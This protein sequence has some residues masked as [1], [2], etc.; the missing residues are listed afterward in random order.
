[1]RWLPLLLVLALLPA[2]AP[3]KAAASGFPEFNGSVYAI[4]A[5]G[6]VLYVGGSF[7]SVVAGG[8][9][10]PRERLA[11]FDAR[12]GSLLGWAPRADRTVRA[13][14]VAGTSVYAG[15]DFGRVSGLRR[16]N[17]VRLDAG[18][19]AVGRFKHTVRGAPYA[20]ATGSG[21]LYVAGSFTAV[22][23]LRRD[24]LA[25]FSLTTD[26]LDARWRPRADD[27]VHSIAAGGARVYVGGTFGAVSGVA[28]TQRVAAVSA[29]TGAVDGGFRPTA[30]GQVNGLAVDATGVYAATG[31][32]GGRAIAWTTNGG[33]RWQRLF[34]GDAV[35]VATAG[36]VTYLGGHFD[37]A[38][39]TPANGARGTCTDRSVA[40]VKMAAM[41]S[42]TGALTRWAPR[43]NGVIGVRTLEVGRSVYA[44][45][46]F[47]TVDG[48]VRRRFAALSASAQ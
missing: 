7:T 5:R 2:P 22:D 37:R 14:A 46:D 11:A 15:G 40:R 36:G 16:D 12:T 6:P 38:C 30:P 23:E 19:G 45:G 24:N 20:L 10:Y 13:L 21:R 41:R 27:A 48:Q 18:T 3:A 43:A 28:R 17:L 32:Q 39:L 34:D 8:R 42:S 4:A 9:S 31:G 35:T 47:T 25:A 1:M 33:V 44:G 29:S 26:A